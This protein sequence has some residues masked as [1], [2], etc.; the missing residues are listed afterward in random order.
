MK[1]IAG[2]IGIAIGV[3]VLA[4]I[5]LFGFAQYQAT[6]I[7][8]GEA[9]QTAKHCDA[10]EKVQIPKLLWGA[11]GPEEAA[12]LAR[13][14]RPGVSP[15]VPEEYTNSI[16]G[17]LRNTCNYRVVAALIVKSEDSEYESFTVPDKWELRPLEEKAFQTGR[18]NMTF[19]RK[20][21]TVVARITEQ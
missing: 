2:V 11:L 7:R 13:P 18:L 16:E 1:T 21:M 4:S 8:A 3:G 14:M 10:A 15:P 6:A 20:G 19:R 17:V 9:T 12:S 5:V